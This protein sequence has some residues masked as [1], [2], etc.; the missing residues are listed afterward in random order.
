MTKTLPTPDLDIG[1]PE[2]TV[3]ELAALW[4]ISAY[5]LREWA[6]KGLVLGAVQRGGRWR[7]PARPFLKAP[8][9]PGAKV[10]DEFMP[11]EL[12]EFP[13]TPAAVA[14]RWSCAEATICSYARQGLLAP[15]V[16]LAR[17]WR[18]RERV[19]LLQSSPRFPHQSTGQDVRLPDPLVAL[20]SLSYRQCARK[21]R[22]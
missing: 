7:F 20:G 21:P 14:F 16:W 11:V 19:K 6:A 2:L 15:C 13:L 5:T 17:G 22:R 10:G 3:E 8:V 12:A 9:R 18:F 4:R 1:G